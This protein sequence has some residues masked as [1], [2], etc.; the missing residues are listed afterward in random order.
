MR[1]ASFEDKGRP[2]YGLVH[3]DGVVDLRKRFGAEVPDLRAL[4]AS[5]VDRASEFTAEAPDQA[6][7][8]VIWQPVIPQPSQIYCI[9]LNYRA[10]AEEVGRPVGEYPPVFVRVAASQVGHLQSIIRPRVSRQLDFEGELALIIGRPG[11]HIAEADA[12]GHIAGYSLYNDAS[13]RDWQRHTPQYTP[14]KNFPAT[15][16]FGPWMVTSDELPHPEQLELTTRLN[17]EIVQHAPLSDLI[18]PIEQIIAYVSSF[19]RLQPGDVIITGTPAGVGS[20]R[21]PKLWLRPGDTVEV[22]IPGIGTLVNP[23]VDETQP[24]MRAA[25]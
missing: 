25:G 18:F 11:R 13:V 21:E 6:L 3:D 15:G 16:A 9:G 7:D 2:S 23:V 17:G 22:E 5:G 12:L 14:G 20:M 8:T 10:H 24:A 4:L 1:L 19:S